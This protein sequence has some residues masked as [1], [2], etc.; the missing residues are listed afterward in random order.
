MQDR[1]G[2]LTEHGRSDGGMTRAGAGH[3]RKA[4]AVAP[5]RNRKAVQ[6]KAVQNKAN[7]FA[8]VSR[9]SVNQA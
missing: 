3:S 1:R 7:I 9:P 4:Q 8:S 6:N 5:R 2:D